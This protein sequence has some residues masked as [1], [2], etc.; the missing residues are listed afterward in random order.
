MNGYF[1]Q[2]TPSKA[3][4]DSESKE[5]S[6]NKILELK[7]NGCKMFVIEYDPIDNQCMAQVWALFIESGEMECILGI[8][9]KL[10]VIPPP[11]ERD[12]NSIT[13]NQRYCKYHVIYS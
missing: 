5:H 4:S 2:V 8:R 7:K 1:K 3:P 11:R 13:K 6:L 12:P 10:Q 9:V